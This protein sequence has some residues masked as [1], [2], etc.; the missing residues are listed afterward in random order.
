MDEHII[1]FFFAVSGR[2]PMV[3]FVCLRIFLAFPFSVLSSMDGWCGGGYI[4]LRSVE[5]V[6]ELKGGV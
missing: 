2:S 5:Q 6:C 1:R 3:C 4:T